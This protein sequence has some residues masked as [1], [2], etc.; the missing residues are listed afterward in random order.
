MFSA[1]ALYFPGKIRRRKLHSIPQRVRPI[2]L[3]DLAVHG[4]RKPS[5]G[6]DN[7]VFREFPNR[8][9]CFFLAFSSSNDLNDWNG[10]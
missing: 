7:R 6:N 5:A 3:L 4:P 10:A 1:V 9:N 2:C 8:S